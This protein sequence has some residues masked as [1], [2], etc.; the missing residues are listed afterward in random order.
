MDERVRTVIALMKDGLRQDLSLEEMAQLVN[1]SSSRLR[2]LFKAETGKSPANYLKSLR[3]QKAK[4]MFETTFMRVKEVANTIGVE[5][6]DRFTKDFKKAYGLT[7][8]E[9]Q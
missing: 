5:N 9:L 8:T 4:E 2:H 6:R 1:P 3:M 7:P